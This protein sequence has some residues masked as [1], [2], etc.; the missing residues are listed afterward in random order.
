MGVVP[1]EKTDRGQANR[2]VPKGW[3]KG[4]LMAFRARRATVIAD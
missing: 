1:E 3:G 4:G 2:K